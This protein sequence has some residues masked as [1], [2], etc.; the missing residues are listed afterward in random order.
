M[1]PFRIFAVFVEV[2][3]HIVDVV[4]H[5]VVFARV[6]RSEA[7]DRETI[8]DCL[9]HHAGGN[10]GSIDCSHHQSILININKAIIDSC[11]YN[12]TNLIIKSM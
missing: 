3:I 1:H 7:V 6:E 12:F 11:N 9:S 10:S 2:E 8:G 5:G 4:V